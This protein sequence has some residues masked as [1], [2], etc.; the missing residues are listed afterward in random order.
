[1]KAQQTNR[2]AAKGGKNNEDGSSIQVHN[3]QNLLMKGNKSFVKS[4]N[5]D[6]LSKEGGVGHIIMVER[7]RGTTQR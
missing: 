5:S 1:M 3:F 4:I 7:R 6:Q 2:I